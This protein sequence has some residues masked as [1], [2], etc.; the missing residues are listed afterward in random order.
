MD[1]VTQIALGA[2]VGE[3]SLGRQ[4][5]SRAIYWGAI[6]G[7][8]PDLDVIFAPW[9][10]T[11]QFLVYHRG[12]SHSLPVAA[13][14]SCAL[15]FV[16]ARWYRREAGAPTRRQWLVFF[17]L[18]LVTHILLDC[19]TSYGTQIWLPFSDT[20]VALSSIFIID[21]LYTIPL[22][23]GVVGSLWFGRR[24]RWRR[25]INGLGLLLSTLYLALTLAN[26]LHVEQVFATALADQRV[27]YQR[28]MT[29]PTPLNNVLWY[30]LAEAVDGYYL[31]YY[32]LLDNSSSV[33]FEFVARREE[34]LGSRRES[35]VVDR[36]IWFADGYYCVRQQAA[37]VVLHVMK[38]GRLSLSGDEEAYPFA[39]LLRGPASDPLVEP[40]PETGTTDMR[41]MLSRLWV[42]LRGV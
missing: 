34:L 17:L 16:F 22:L 30:G 24:S 7:T 25:T 31:G 38:F 29:C 39:Y 11:V 4:L 35:Y 19:L 20:R 14:A 26:K 28:L 36:L 6:F 9:W 41:E 1:S 33:S 18:V 5:G 40:A 10:D 2:A 37:G 13:A 3:W 15:A 27:T 12:L 21:P 8:L 23:A 32:S 42:R